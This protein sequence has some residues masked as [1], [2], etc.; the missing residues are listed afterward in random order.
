MRDHLQRALDAVAERR[1]TDALD[2]LLDAWRER[3]SPGVADLID[4]LSARV[5]APRSSRGAARW[6]A[7]R[8]RALDLV[9]L[10]ASFRED[11]LRDKPPSERDDLLAAFAEADGGALREPA[12]AVERGAL[13]AALAKMRL[14]V[15]RTLLRSLR[16]WRDDPRLASALVRAVDATVYEDSSWS[17]EDHA[18]EVSSWLLRL[19]DPRTVPALRATLARWDDAPEAARAQLLRP[20]NIGGSKCAAEAVA[21]LR[22]TVAQL[23]HLDDDRAPLDPAESSRCEAICALL[24]AIPTA[25]EAR[26]AVRAGRLQRVLAAPSDRS[27]REDFGRWLRERGDPWGDLFASQLGPATEAWTPEREAEDDLV[28]QLVDDWLGALAT[29]GDGWRFVGGMPDACDLPWPRRAELGALVENPLWASV[30]G[31]SVGR[32]RIGDALEPALALLRH[33]RLASVREA[34]VADRTLLVALAAG[35]ETLPWREFSFRGDLLD[36]ETLGSFVPAATRDVIDALSVAPALPRLAALTLS[37]RTWDGGCLPSCHPP[38]EFRWLLRSPLA[39]RLDALQV[40]DVFDHDLGAWLEEIASAPDRVPP[41]QFDVGGRWRWRAERCE[42]DGRFALE[43]SANRW[44]PR[45]GESRWAIRDLRATL[46][47][48]DPARIQRLA[49]ALPPDVALTSDDLAAL[50]AGVARMPGV[51]YAGP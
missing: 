39:R 13:L 26:W 20:Y 27:A 11:A 15:D 28:A 1:L 5:E 23:A 48:L 36:G 32:A 3:R 12:D 34:A 38:G 37:A 43:A 8:R 50:H 16:A 40:Q 45:D 17:D 2:P 47:R 19:A 14:G 7:H 21:W 9:R 18:E 24:R 51:D 33:P 22:R 29:L 30:R 25:A 4:I 41:V 42:A 44:A 46:D 31:V 49:V 6:W 35:P 10:P